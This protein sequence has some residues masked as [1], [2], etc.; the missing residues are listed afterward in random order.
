MGLCISFK[1]TPV[2]PRHIFPLKKD[3]ERRDY[4]S[5]HTFFHIYL[6]L[7]INR[8]CSWNSDSCLRNLIQFYK[9]SDSFPVSKL[10][11]VIY[12]SGIIIIFNIF[13][14]FPLKNYL[15]INNRGKNTFQNVLRLLV[16]DIVCLL[17]L[18][19]IFMWTGFKWA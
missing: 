3:S 15:I 9:T 7:Q 13:P 18:N 17:V 4:K 14:S 8:H 10:K 12:N 5:N 1:P 16:R 6:F 2:H 11:T 19:A